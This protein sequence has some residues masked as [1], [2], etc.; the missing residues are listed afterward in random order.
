VENGFGRQLGRRGRAWAVVAVALMAALAARLFYIQVV[1]HDWYVRKAELTRGRRWPI[2]APRGNI[3]DRNG[4][5]LALNLKLFA[6]AAD[7]REIKDVGKT[8][9]E[10][11]PLLRMKEEELASA[12]GRDTRYVALR[13]TVDEPVAEAIRRLND[14]GVIVSTEWKRA[15]PH[16]QAGAALLGFVG[17]DM[18]GLGGTE[19]ALE[20]DLAGDDGE[21]LVALDGRLPG[22]RNQVPGQTVVVKE[23]MPGS[24][25]VLTIDLEIQAMAEEA[26]AKAVEEA[27]AVGGT[28]IVM[29]PETGE[30]LAL[31]AQPGFDP[32]EF[33]RYS[34]GSWVS[35]A[36]VSPYEPGSTFKVITACAAMEEGVMSHGETYTCTGSRQVGNRKIS[37]AL[38]AG[39]RA[40]GTLNLDEMIV[41]SCNVGM[42]TV[43]L[44]LGA[45]RLHRWAARLGCG[46]RTGIEL[47]GESAG[48]L[49]P[50]STW[51]QVQV[52]NVG[53]GQ[54]ISVTA[55]QLL[56]A[57]A[58]VA[59]GGKL[60]HPHLVKMVLEPGGKA[61]APARSGGERVLSEATCERM[62][63]ALERVVEE[64]TG[65][66]AQIAG[67]R[68]AGKTG[69]AQKPTPEAGYKSGK[70]IGSF[71]GFAPVETPRVAILV[72][73]DEPKASHYGG[74]VAA[75]AFRE[76]CERTLAYLHVPPD[77]VAPGRRVASA[78]VEGD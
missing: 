5:P 3:Y 43:G 21:M 57:Y 27:D 78:A 34:P 48:M 73:V 74:V 26:L 45:K 52:A 62:K 24:S 66:R 56:A 75:P 12:L 68:V 2:H 53:F 76:I 28:A 55:L 58:A 15:Y 31:A 1:E 16:G 6:V 47:A 61:T 35:H 8:A 11:A 49:P 19:A 70:Y 29:D 65:K 36:V 41:K 37:C 77:Q 20:R 71:V 50:A 14:R 42:G 18:E 67:R 30:V 4:N 13:P 40:H 9:K 10:L 60:V 59:N 72:A 51:S 25:A 38:H 46:K 17:K 69:T 22:S 23:M 33:S 44:A 64:G 63:Q 7:P 32:N 54:G 39:A